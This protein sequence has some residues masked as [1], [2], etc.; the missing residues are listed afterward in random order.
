MD[1]AL[2]AILVVLTF[3]VIALSMYFLW[4]WQKRTTDHDTSVIPKNQTCGISGDLWNYNGEDLADSMNVPCTKCIQFLTKT[5]EG[6]FPMQYDGD[7]KCVKY[8]DPEPCPVK[9]LRQT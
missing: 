3:F 6:C 9:T 5:S 8:G 7:S 2:L 4:P 1:S